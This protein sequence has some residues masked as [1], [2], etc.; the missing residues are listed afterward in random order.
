VWSVRS[1]ALCLLGAGVLTV[2]AA[3]T[4]A[5]D[6]VHGITIGDRAADATLPPDEAVGPAVLLGTAVFVAFAMLP[7]TSEYVTGSIRSTF[8]AQPRRRLV[9]AAK[10]AVTAGSGLVVGV[11]TGWAAEAGSR[12]VLGDHAAPSGTPGPL[13]L[14]VGAVLALDAVLVAG[15]ASLLRSPVGTLAA[16][17]TITSAALMLP[18]RLN[19]WTPAGATVRLISGDHGEYPAGP[20]ALAVLVAWSA[21]VYAA[22]SWLLERRDA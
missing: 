4:L 15:L 18:D 2:L 19:A 1:P 11:V 12:L 7:V 17:M 13:A 22:G 14:N 20:V 8:L 16:G 9:L 10:T 21:A 6:F 5:N 3:L